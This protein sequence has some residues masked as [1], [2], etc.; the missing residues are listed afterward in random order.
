MFNANIQSKSDGKTNS[1]TANFYLQFETCN[2]K[3]PAPMA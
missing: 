1:R 3:L 2:L